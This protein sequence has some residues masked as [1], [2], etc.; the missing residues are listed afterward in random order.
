MIKNNKRRCIHHSGKYTG[1]HKFCEGE[2]ILTGLA[3]FGSLCATIKYGE[4]QMKRRFISTFTI[5]VTLGIIS[6]CTVP[7]L[8]S[9]IN[10]FSGN[11]ATATINATGSAV[12]IADRPLVDTQNNQGQPASSSVSNDDLKKSA[13]DLKKSADDLKKAAD[14]IASSSMQASSSERIDT[15]FDEVVG[16][17]SGSIPLKLS[18]GSIGGALVEVNDAV[19][20]YVKNRLTAVLSGDVNGIY[21]HDEVGKVWERE[22]LDIPPGNVVK[23]HAALF[24]T[25]NA[26]ESVGPIASIDWAKR[27]FVTTD[28]STASIPESLGEGNYPPEYLNRYV[29]VGDGVAIWAWSNPPSI[30]R[31]KEKYTSLEL[32]IVKGNPLYW[33]YDPLHGRVLV[34]SQT[35]DNRNHLYRLA[36]EKL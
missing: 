11:T 12:I 34:L 35:D 24:Q 15:S 20:S 32:G 36:G 21:S 1:Y 23:R 27:E 19:W 9:T 3:S 18:D 10:L 4:S 16:E 17:F 7:D 30:S 25:V 26:T 6:G 8:P 14:T 2:Y 29:I 31:K 22:P 13:D 5:S 28:G 33:V